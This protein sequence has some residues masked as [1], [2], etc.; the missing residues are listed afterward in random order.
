MQNGSDPDGDFSGRECPT[1]R[2]EQSGIVPDGNGK[3]CDEGGGVNCET[4][5]DCERH[6][7]SVLQALNSIN[8]AELMGADCETAFTANNAASDC[9]H[10]ENSQL[11]SNGESIRR[12][13]MRLK[14]STTEITKALNSPEQAFGNEPPSEALNCMGFRSNDS[15]QWSQTKSSTPSRRVRCPFSGEERNIVKC[16]YTEG[17]GQCA[18]LRPYSNCGQSITSASSRSRDN[19]QGNVALPG[20]GQ[21]SQLS[22]DE[23]MQSLRTAMCAIE[24][25]MKSIGEPTKKCPEQAV[26][27]VP[28]CGAVT[29]SLSKH[30]MCD[31]DS[32]AES[33]PYSS[34]FLDSPHLREWV[35]LLQTLARCIQPNARLPSND[36]KSMIM[37]T[38]NILKDIQNSL[39][40]QE[41]ELCTTHEF[42]QGINGQCSEFVDKPTVV[43]PD[44]NEI[45]ES[46]LLCRI[47]E[48]LE[49]IIYSMRPNAA[50]VG[51]DLE[52]WLACLLMLL[53]DIVQTECLESYKLQ[54]I[55]KLLKCL[56]GEICRQV[57]GNSEILSTIREIQAILEILNG[58]VD[59]NGQCVSTQCE[60]TLQKTPQLASIITELQKLIRCSRP[61]VVFPSCDIQSTI[62]CI[63]LFLKDGIQRGLVS[64]STG[65]NMA[66]QL[67]G[68]DC[69]IMKQGLNNSRL[70]DNIRESQECIQKMLD[71]RANQSD[72][73]RPKLQET[74]NL[75]KVV[76]I[77]QKAIQ[78]IKNE[79]QF[80]TCDLES[81]ILGLLKM[82]TDTLQS[83]RPDEKMAKRLEKI[84]QCLE[85]EVSKQGMQ[86]SDISSAILE[87]QQS[88][89]KSQAEGQ[90]TCDQC[91]EPIKETPQLTDAI[92]KLRELIQCMTP[93]VC[94]VEDD[95][96]TTIVGLLGVLK[97]VITPT[98]SMPDAVE[99]VRSLLKVL[100]CEMR[101]Q[102]A[103]EPKILDYIH[104]I[105]C[106]LAQATTSNTQQMPGNES[107]KRALSSL[108]TANSCIKNL[109]QVLR[110]FIESPLHT[111][112]VSPGRVAKC[113]G[114]CPLTQEETAPPSAEASVTVERAGICQNEHPCKHDEQMERAAEASVGL[115]VQ[116][117]L[118]ISCPIA[119]KSSPSSANY[120]DGQPVEYSG[121]SQNPYP[122]THDE[123][124]IAEANGTIFSG[125]RPDNLP[126]SFAEGGVSCPCHNSE[127]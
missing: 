108:I 56:E 15:Q 43:C 59:T 82:S 45:T 62:S 81:R 127:N 112:D 64:V 51:C 111:R 33:S 32:K 98:T 27:T 48:T 34:A 68:L 116:R 19:I 96:G 9:P 120:P 71:A 77:L 8:S 110:Q 44:D 20:C 113:S 12:I 35:T 21:N 88:L 14:Q 40:D 23:P 60:L 49:K 52:S 72:P 42:H 41:S 101:S 99:R 61:D 122:F 115:A 16:P 104:E 106:A 5:E 70:A 4:A 86:Q 117:A 84:M 58:E 28:E 91:L 126:D 47:V 53:K 29:A 121:T 79:A 123:W 107:F 73:R 17:S 31:L 124:Q 24:K 1:Y 63:M 92:E 36:F 54:T 100:E 7:L 74:P 109:E 22:A 125:A 90:N 46:P 80:S 78:H 10:N 3:S 94:L 11:A 39:E 50:L 114:T 2:S 67:K 6:Q 75:C 97:K 95:L 57:G 93:S 76:V 85:C 38:V 103:C 25:V 65:E 37:C 83:V 119:E 69:E 118:N 66:Q 30:K 18:Q 26:L 55:S 89:Q 105:Q 13:I 102:G 87:V